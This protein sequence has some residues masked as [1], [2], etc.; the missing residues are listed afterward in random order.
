M[1]YQIQAT[2][3]NRDSER[4]TKMAQIP[5]FYLDSEIQGIVSDD[6]AEHIAGSILNPFGQD[7]GISISVRA[8]T[9]V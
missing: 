5:T 9:D 7:I 4:W 8:M 1:L 2:V 3:T 6:H